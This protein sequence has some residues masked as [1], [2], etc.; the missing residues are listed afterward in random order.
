MIA[1][2]AHGANNGTH[3]SL[4]PEGKLHKTSRAKNYEA[5]VNMIMMTLILV[6]MVVAI[7]LYRSNK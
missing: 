7:V 4:N 1:L 3:I 2:N 6:G 5:L